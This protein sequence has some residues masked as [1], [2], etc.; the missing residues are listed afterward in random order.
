MSSSSDLFSSV[1]PAVQPGAGAKKTP[2]AAA[3]NPPRPAAKKPPP[4]QPAAAAES[5]PESPAGQAKPSAA[6]APAASYRV[7]ARSYRPSCFEDLIGQ[8]ALVQTLAHAFASNRVAHAF[9]LT[10]QRGVGKT[11]TARLIARRLNYTGKAGETPLA[12]PETGAHCQAILASR[13]MDVIEMDAASRTGI[14]DVREIIENT[15]YRPVMAKHKVYIIDE[16]HMLSTAAFNGLLKTL[17]EP[18]DHVTFIFATTEI[19]KVPLTVLSRCQRFDLRRLNGEQMFGLLAR[20]ARAENAASSE[21]A[22]R[23]IAYAAEGSARDGLSLLDQA[24]LAGEGEVNAGAVRSMLGLAGR[25]ALLDLLD[26]IFAGELA[27][28]LTSFRDHCARGSDA[29]AVLTELAALVH[30]LSCRKAGA[31]AEYDLPPAARE[32]AGAMAEKLS[33][34]Q[35]SLVWQM[36]LQALEECRQTN[37]LQEAGEMALIRLA[38][39]ASLPPPETA[40]ALL[41]ENADPLLQEIYSTFPGAAP[42]SQ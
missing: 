10:G 35:L 34:G 14:N 38:H 31:E 15:S 26:Q 42:I 41:R 5:P 1:E 17:E 32:R 40:L 33:L 30:M 13:H 27:A 21:D 9:M 24:I 37:A 7:L 19:R 22:L 6:P 3:K 11:T 39:S 25:A 18:P 8:D 16:V 2:P 29:L 36:L 4:A 23:M 20:T 12:M 28:S